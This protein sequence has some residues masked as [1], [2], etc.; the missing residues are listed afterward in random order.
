MGKLVWE[1]PIF[2]DCSASAAATTASSTNLLD[3]SYLAAAKTSQH[4]QHTGHG[5]GGLRGI[6]DDD[7]DDE[8]FFG[9]DGGGGRGKGG[10]V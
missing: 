10:E 9:A 1:H 8:Y 6:D 4:L 5:V 3:R 2:R 7:D